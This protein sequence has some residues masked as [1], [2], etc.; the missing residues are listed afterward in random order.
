[1]VSEKP[2]SRRSKAQQE[3]AVIDLEANAASTDAEKTS[4]D[5]A[6]DAALNEMPDAIPADAPVSETKIPAGE[7]V[8]TSEIP[9][10]GEKPVEA[11]ET[12]ED[13]AASKPVEATPAPAT[14]EKAPAK[15]GTSLS[16]ALA[17]GIFGGLVAL[18]GAGSMQYAGYLPTLSGTSSSA[19]S[20]MSTLEAEVATLKSAVASLASRPTAHVDTSALE[21]RIAALEAAP[22]QTAPSG[23]PA[24]LEPIQQKLAAL[25]GT[26]TQIEGNLAGAEEK[27]KSLETEFL[28]RLQK[29]EA[30]VN[31]PARRNAVARAIAA[32]G[33]KAAIDRGGS[34]VAE[35]ET[36]AGV[37]ANDPAIAGLKP[38]ADTGVPTRSALIARF[39]DA[40]NAVLATLDKPNPDQNVASRLW[41][42]ALSLVKVRPVGEVQGDTPEAFLAR[43]E[44]ALKNGDLDRAL[45]EWNGL[46]EEGRAAAADFAQALS[47]RIEVEKL[48]GATL[49]QA[50]IGAAGNGQ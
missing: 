4:G 11:P 31:D 19:S 30:E 7:G 42:S 27:Q 23:A 49:K 6:L 33:L 14:A 45:A 10:T 15:S 2:S 47:A 39:P 9:A 34:F 38:Y 3:P 24:D 1:M 28:D 32:S 29:M 12:G 35:L 41:S 36:F 44:N 20:T 22:A 13:E 50:V 43:S 16:G 37:D 18:A 46:P 25:D 17:A 8:D 5:Q 26:V 21:A 40:A 48:V